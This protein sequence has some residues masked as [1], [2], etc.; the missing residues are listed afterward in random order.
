MKIPDTVVEEVLSSADIVDIVGETVQLKKAG[1]SYK[2]LC[3]F[4]GEKTPSFNDNPEKNLFYCF[5]CGA[6]GNVITFVSRFHNLSFTDAV[7]FLAERYGISVQTGKDDSKRSGILGLHEDIL[8][9]TKRRLLS[10][11]GKEARDYI[12]S[13]KF[14]G[15]VVEEF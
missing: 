4:H 3:P 11:E 8:L 6:G 12:A 5:G 7:M 15:E 1:N 14:A 13:R 2:G 9:E 10:A